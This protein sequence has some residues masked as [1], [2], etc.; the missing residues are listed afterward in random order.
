ML[1]GSEGAEWLKAAT[2][3]PNRHLDD[4][5]DDVKKNYPHYTTAPQK[6]GV[7]DDL[8]IRR[9][10]STRYDNGR[11]GE[12]RASWVQPD[13]LRVGEEHLL[14][15]IPKHQWTNLFQGPGG[16]FIPGPTKIG[17]SRRRSGSLDIPSAIF[18]ILVVFELLQIA[19]S[20]R[21]QLSRLMQCR[22]KIRG[23]RAK[24]MV[25]SGENILR[26]LEV[27]AREGLQHRRTE[28]RESHHLSLPRGREPPATTAWADT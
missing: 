28:S 6:P 24:E 19:P 14:F 2:D 12:E 4:T 25:T 7:L 10:T 27:Q 23:N 13:D 1:R 22:K 5:P 18:M 16:S 9:A 15:R 3:A 11:T 20:V 21:Q 26:E 17:S 8:T